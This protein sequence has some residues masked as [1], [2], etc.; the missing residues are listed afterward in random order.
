MTSSRARCFSSL[1]PFS[2]PSRLA[3]DEFLHLGNMGRGD[4]DAG[5]CDHRSGAA[6]DNRLV[7]HLA[8]VVLEEKLQ[9]L[10]FL[11]D[12]FQCRG[13]LFIVLALQ[14]G[15]FL[16][17]FGQVLITA[18]LDLGNFGVDDAGLFA[19]GDGDFI[20]QA[21]EGLLAGILIHIADDVLG[22]VQHPVQ[23]AARDIQ[24]HAQVGGDAAGVPDVRHRAWPARYGPC[25]RGGPTSGSLP[26]R[27]YRR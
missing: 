4:L 13:S 21:F 5:F 19:L 26:R 24:Q 18:G 15:L 17:E 9:A 14:L 22:K 23:V 27:I 6:E 16:L 11:D 12:G 2:I 20:L 25:V 1:S 3:L 8:L 10:A 7:E